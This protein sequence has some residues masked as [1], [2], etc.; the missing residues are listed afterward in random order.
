MVVHSVLLTA[1]YLKKIVC[2]IC[3]YTKMYATLLSQIH[4]YMFNSAS[5]FHLDVNVKILFNIELSA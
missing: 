3:K 2:E 4:C 5:C 1:Y